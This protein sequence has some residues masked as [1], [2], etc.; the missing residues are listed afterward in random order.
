MRLAHDRTDPATYEAARGGHFEDRRLA[1]VT[2]AIDA[3]R[4]TTVIEVGAGTGRISSRLACRFP[5]ISFLAVEIDHHLAAYGKDTYPLTNLDWAE[6]LPRNAE[7][8]V[9]FSID[10]I[11]HLDNRGAMFDDIRDTMTGRGVWVAIEPNIW[12]P[13]IWLSQ[14]RMRRAGLGEDHYRPWISEPE[15]RR[16]GFS[17][18]SRRYLH[19]WPAAFSPR[20]GRGAERSLERFR[21]LGGSVVYHLRRL[22]SEE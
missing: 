16:A 19:L 2:E 6:E 8:G 20:L 12:H 13:A 3:Q 21:H 18:E 9:V 4:P 15:L 5:A 17:I 7:A 14:E 10:V 1:L 11:H 22:S